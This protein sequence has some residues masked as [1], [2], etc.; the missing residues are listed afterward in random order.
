LTARL[1]CVQQSPH[2][3]EWLWYYDRVQPSSF[4]KRG[5]LFYLNRMQGKL[6]ACLLPR[7]GAHEHIRRNHLNG[8]Q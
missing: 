1:Y 8:R 4:R 6:L 5:S 7:A 2:S 3:Q